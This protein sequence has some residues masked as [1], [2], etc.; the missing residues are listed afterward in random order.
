MSNTGVSVTK[1][2]DVRSDLANGKCGDHGKLET[3]ISQ[4]MPKRPRN[5]P[6]V[7]SSSTQASVSSVA[8]TQ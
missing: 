6:M 2:G 8:E 3:W 7:S 4:S 1:V 5:G